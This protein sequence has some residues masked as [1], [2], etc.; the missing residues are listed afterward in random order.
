MLAVISPQQG[1]R[2]VVAD[3]SFV[4]RIEVQSSTCPRGDV[5]EVAQGRGKV[6][7]RDVRIEFPCLIA[8]HPREEV[9]MMGREVYAAGVMDS[10]S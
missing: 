6:I 4:L 5:A 3:D 9:F 8:P 10:M 2:L 7:D 1:G